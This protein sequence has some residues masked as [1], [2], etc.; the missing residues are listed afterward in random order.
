[1]REAA[2]TIIQAKGS[3]FY[4]VAQA[5]ATITQAVLR[6]ERRILP[7]TAVAKEFDGFRETAFSYPRIVGKE[8]VVQELKYEL[9]EEETALLHQSIQF[10]TENIESAGY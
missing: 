4:A 7:I 5:V 2:Q 3:T 1:M 8:G 9:S 6:D 10:I